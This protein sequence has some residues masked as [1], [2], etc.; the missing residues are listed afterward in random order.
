MKSITIRIDD[1]TFDFFQNNYKTQTSGATRAAIGWGALQKKT[2][3]SIKGIFS[4]AQLSA[5]IDVFNAS[6]ILQT[7]ELCT[8]NVI[9]TEFEDACKLNSLQITWEIKEK[10]TCELIKQLSFV[11]SLFLLNWIDRFWQT[12]NKLEKYVKELARVNEDGKKLG[13]EIEK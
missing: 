3:A 4:A 5:L 7:P 9:L 6:L 1:K 11:Q 12:K 2:L 13:I 8:S 10:E